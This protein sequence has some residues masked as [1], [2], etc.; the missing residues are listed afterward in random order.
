MKEYADKIA[1]ILGG[2]TMLGG[3][4]AIICG[5]VGLGLL[6]LLVGLLLV[7][8]FY[9]TMMRGSGNNPD[10]G[11]FNGLAGQ[12]KQQS[13]VVQA[14][15]SEPGEQTPAVWDKMEVNE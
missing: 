1:V 10:Q 2:V 6:A 7:S 12:G 11:I 5:K 15:M 3:M 14:N 13:E 4:V 9:A 8:L